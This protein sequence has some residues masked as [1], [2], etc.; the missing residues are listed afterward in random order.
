M[1]TILYAS[2]V[3]QQ[4]QQAVAPCLFYIHK[5]GAEDYS[6]LLKLS[7]ISIKDVRQ[8]LTPDGEPLNEAYTEQLKGVIGEIF[9]PEVPFR[10]TSNKKACRYCDYR[11]LCGR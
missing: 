2:I 6:P 4:E 8:P 9:D 3:A 11:L 5:S 10:Q 7:K 1:Q